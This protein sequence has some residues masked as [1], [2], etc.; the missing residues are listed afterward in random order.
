MYAQRSRLL[1]SLSAFAALLLIPLGATAISSA[2]AASGRV[3]HPGVR[4]D[5]A[6]A[7][8][9]HPSVR[10]HDVSARA[11]RLHRAARS[12]AA[13]VHG[14]RDPSTNRTLSDATMRECSD[15][16]SGQSCTSAVLAG[17]DAARAREGVRP[18]RLPADWATR[19]ATQ[20]LFLVADLER[21]DRGLVPAAGLARSLNRR[22]WAGARAN[23]DPSLE[24]MNGNWAGSNWAG[25]F[26][27]VLEADFEWMYDDGPGSPNIDCAAA[28]QS[29][30][31][32]HRD[33]IL[34]PYQAPLAMGAAVVGVSMAEL[35]VGHD[36]ATG[37]HQADALGA[38]RWPAVARRS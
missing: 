23:T 38:P 25:G 10:A 14:R 31:W 21:V 4:A 26:G 33:N 35:F 3:P 34:A 22:A 11:R 36:V 28:G 7:G 20:Q 15:N 24:P 37:P 5:H 19:S 1:A 13:L 16:P 8:A 12:R 6:H 18:I 29:G 17:V 2:A 32:G 9:L 27:S 30:C